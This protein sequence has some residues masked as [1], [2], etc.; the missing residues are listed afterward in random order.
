MSV[1]G[2]DYSRGSLHVMGIL[3]IEPW[4]LLNM[5][6]L[7]YHAPLTQTSIAE[8]N[9]APLTSSLNLKEK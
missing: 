5:L 4:K 8:K 7:A 9:L 3:S 1:E 6:L 2:F